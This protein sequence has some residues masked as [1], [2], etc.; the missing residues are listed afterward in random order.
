MAFVKGKMTLEDTRKTRVFPLNGLGDFLFGY[1]WAVDR[2]EDCWL[3]LAQNCVAHNDKGETKIIEMWFF[4]WKGLGFTF[5]PKKIYNTHILDASLKLTYVIGKD[6]RVS[7][8]D[9]DTFEE[10]QR[11]HRELTA[12]VEANWEAIKIKM[13]EA[14]KTYGDDG[15]IRDQTLPENVTVIFRE[16]D[17][18]EQ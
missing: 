13:T 8:P 3:T 7:F 15:D 2:E 5:Y 18:N 6:W 11:I 9:K 16:G 17:N 14:F 10:N 1:S 12:E 4:Y